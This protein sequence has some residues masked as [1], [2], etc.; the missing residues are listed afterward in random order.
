MPPIQNW[1]L[2]PLRTLRLAH[3]AI[4][5]CA[6]LLVTATGLHS[7]QQ[8][9]EFVRLVAD[10][11]PSPMTGNPVSFLVFNDRLYFSATDGTHGI[12]LWQTD[13]T[14]VT[15]L[16]D[17]SY[18]SVNSFVSSLKV[19]NGQIY[20][21]AT[22]TTNNLIDLELWKYDG[23]NSSQ[24]AEV[25]PTGNAGVADLTEFNGVLYFTATDG[26]TGNELWAHDGFN[27]YQVVDLNSGPANSNPS[28][29]MVYNGLL[30][31]AAS[32]SVSG[33]EF[34]TFDGFTLTSANINSGSANSNPSGFTEFNGILYFQATEPT[35]GAELWA[36]DGF[37][38]YRAADIRNGTASSS[39]ANFK[40]FNG[41]LYFAANDGVNGVE[42]WKYDGV[43]APVRV[44]QIASGSSSSS[45]ANLQVY[46]N[47][48]YFAAADTTTGTELWKFDGS[49]ATRVADINTGSANSSPASLTVFNGYLY[50][51][52]TDAPTSRQL[53]R[54]DGTT[55]SRF[56]RIHNGS[57]GSSVGPGAVF[58]GYYYLTA[59]GI[60]N[61]FYKY[62]G[63]N[64]TVVTTTYVPSFQS[65]MVVYK[66]NLHFAST[67]PSTTDQI[68]RY[69]GTNFV[70]LGGVFNGGFAELV[71]YKG[72]LYFRGRDSTHG[73]EIWRCNG[74]N[75]A[76][77]TDIY[78]GTSSSSPFGLTVANG[79]L[80]FNATDAAGLGFFKFDGTNATRINGILT[81][82]GG[83]V[84][85]KGATYVSGSTNGNRNELCRYDGTNLTQVV[86]INAFN[87]NAASVVLLVFQNKLLFSAND[88]IHGSKFWLYD[89]TN[90][91]PA[92]DHTK[93]SGFYPFVVADTLYFTAYQSSTGFELWKIDDTNTVQVADINPGLLDSL[94]IPHLAYNGS[95]YFEANDG[96]N[97]TE[98]WRLDPL[99][100]LVRITSVARQGN[101][102]KL[103]WTT[104]GGYSN[105]LQ[106]ANSS[107]NGSFTNNFSDRSAPILASTG[108]LVTISYTDPG[109]A[110][111]FP[112]RYYRVRVP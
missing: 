61:V 66:N 45:P 36:F 3:Q 107:L 68:W 41:N 40:V 69:D 82:S 102:I 23:V 50:F 31:F 93:P 54:F 46:N 75:V 49:N 5:I 51:A 12:E 9:R 67:G 65:G 42:L 2:F 60:S 78:P 110:T 63:T 34:Y 84:A 17:I 28:G 48:L 53:W 7:Q 16:T 33:T 96:A 44:T 101:D 35:G 81:G 32:N 6:V 38:Y 43:S 76:F 20:F 22:G 108:T 59:S 15:R 8:P 112:A 88:G 52:A 37:S 105:V 109:G 30:C 56:A 83:A 79:L 39:P 95:Y 94:P 103:S 99:S 73:E 47:T 1:N 80:Y 100:Q 25:N 91:V 104:P 10:F 72:N 58:N 87:T 111:N 74:T 18:G 14:N 98:L 29:L 55:A 86:Q 64:T 24:V 85:Y 92:G 77:N 27:T 97:G 62:D 11:N 71:E 19:F 57:S 106:S 4:L 21:R 13:G 89:G 90:A 70:S 26:S